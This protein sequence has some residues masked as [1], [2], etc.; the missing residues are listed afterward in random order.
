MVA[1]LCNDPGTKNRQEKEHHQSMQPACDIS[2]AA[3]P[4]AVG[5]KRAH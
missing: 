5:S 3:D 1:L 2:T 4:T